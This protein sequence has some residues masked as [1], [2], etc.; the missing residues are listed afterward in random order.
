[1]NRGLFTILTALL[2]VA[3]MHA[4]QQVTVSGYGWTVTADPAQST[5]TVE[6]ER[7]G[8]VL[9]NVRLGL[10][11]TEAVTGWA[12]ERSGQD[13]LLIRSSR[14][15]M[16]WRFEP[17][18]D[19]LTISSTSY[20][21]QLTATAPVPLTRIPVR[22]LDRE[23]TPVMWRGN[24]EAKGTYGAE[25]PAV[26]SFLP[27]HN[28][29]V[30]YFSLGQVSNPLL[31]SLFDRSTGI[32]IDFPLHT[33][34]LRNGADADEIAVTIP[35]EGSALLRLYSDY[36][37]KTLGL[38]FYVP[39]D[40]TNF[41]SAPM[42]WSSWTSY[43]EDVTEADI[44]RNT[45]W[46]AENLRPYGFQFVQLDDGYDRGETG[47]HYWIENWDR[48]KFPHGPQWLTSYIRSKGLRPGIWLV[49]NAYAGAVQQHPEWYLHYKKD[50]N[51]IKD[52]NTPALDATN[53]E[54]LNDVRKIMTTLDDWGF[55]YY[56]FDGEFALPHYI[57]GVD[58]D[59]LHDPNVDPL[60]NYRTRLDMIR[61][62][63]GP[64]RF[65]EG[66]PAGTPLNGIGFFNSYFTGQ[67]LYANWD[68]MF[69][70]FSSITGSAFLNH[71]AVYV[72]P[73]EGMEVGSH[74]SVEEAAKKRP[75]VVL[76]T[77]RERESPVTGVGT[78]TAEAR[79]VVSWVALTGVVYP[80]ASVMPEVPPDRLELL[81]K[82]LP[83]MPILPVDLF[84]R[85]SDID[86]DTFK[87]TT[88]DTYIHHYPEILDLKVNA[89]AGVYDVAA[90]T[91]W[92]S[93]PASRSVSLAEKLG[94]SDTDD[95]VVF[96]FWNQ[97]L[98]GVFRNKIDVAVEP[99]DT[100]VLLIHPLTDHPQ[101][102][103]IS[104]HITGAFSLEGYQWD[105]SSRRLS[106]VS[107]A[108]VG[109]RYALT[110]YV[111][112]GD[113]FL[114]ATATC[115]G[116]P[117]AIASTQTGNVVTVSFPGQSGKVEWNVWFDR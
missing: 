25:I 1:M 84:S 90:F 57:P 85:G 71:L 47:Q 113:S 26:P 22:L 24:G 20:D 51:I 53:P 115:G 69:P 94:L 72:M 60:V 109:E 15:V 59:R 108:I 77:I 3:G 66:C 4:Q 74:M 23:G 58:R 102:V 38:P 70:L 104:R 40:D 7:L 86:W 93:Q 29:E 56:K 63:I 19:T 110:I 21:A 79:T 91:N 39:F 95:Y 28:P 30:M 16:A 105:A 111:P 54:A 96:D 107:E 73:G 49:P 11:G 101:L 89:A 83:T 82:T 43:Y 2:L 87:H 55:D 34:M 12:A 45:D 117:V 78:T 114:R 100:R 18:P 50:G 32:A 64:N 68:G 65:I 88:P 76:D 99:H 62:T 41:P 44:V 106:G 61:E 31:H 103:G 14:P 98:L 27:R 17:G 35:V 97:K 46:L 67:D 6:H 48:R 116:K 37:T 52:Y 33:R 92:R 75:R 42:V 10:R 81:H 13:Q 9:R 112:R 5:V 36:F 8:P 80:L